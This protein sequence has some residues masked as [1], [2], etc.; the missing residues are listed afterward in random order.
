MSA[1]D[2]SLGLMCDLGEGDLD[3]LPRSQVSI[4]IDLNCP[5]VTLADG[6][7]D[8]GAVVSEVNSFNDTD[9]ESNFPEKLMLSLGRCL[10]VR[11][12]SLPTFGG[13]GG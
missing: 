3:K 12:F 1:I 8:I 5:F 6:D 9:G 4:C 2:V 7:F 10:G 13:G 11:L